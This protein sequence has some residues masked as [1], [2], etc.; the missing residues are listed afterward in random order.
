VDSSSPRPLPP[1]RTTVLD[2]PG[3]GRTVI[4]DA[5][6]PPDS[7]TLVLLHGVALTAELNW[8]GI[9]EPLRSSY[10]VIMLDLRGHGN[11][12]RTSDFRLEDCVDDVAAVAAALDIERLI[13]VGY[14]MGGLVAQL[15]WRRHPG[16]VSGLVL[17]STARNVSGSP[18][19]RAAALAIPLLVAGAAWMPALHVLRA[20][21][22]GAALLDREIDP[23]DRRWALSQMRRTNLINALSAVQAV[24]GFTS[25]T[26]IGTV[27]VP[28]A[29][30]I[31]RHDRVVHPR[32]Q[33]KLARALPGSTVVE[34]DGGHDV[35]LEAPGR[36]AAAV[37]AACA[38]V[39][40]GAGDRAVGA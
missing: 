37:E 8:G 10:R 32:R 13:A 39:C 11:G 38:A 6:G 21:L 1:V 35:F 27:D 29:V 20:D 19:E 40:A 24:A 12:V 31:T 7:P 5:P 26:W 16:L 23:A 22:I 25:H 3:R 34:I 28:S 9:V 36:L 4:E 33:Q 14:S 30:V 18:W 17:C 15:L 2:L